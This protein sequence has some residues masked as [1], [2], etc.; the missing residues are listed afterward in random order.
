MHGLEWIDCRPEADQVVAAAEGRVVNLGRVAAHAHG[1]RLHA[2][3]GALR[4]RDLFALEMGR[5]FSRGQ[6]PGV[7]PRFVHEA[8]KTVATAL[9][10]AEVQRMDTWPQFSGKET[11]GH[12]PAVA[13][14][15]RLA[16][17]LA[18][19]RRHVRPL[20]DRQRFQIAERARGNEQG[21]ARAWSASSS[22]CIALAIILERSLQFQAAA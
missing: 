11:L 19:G 2:R 10:G 16:R 13:V 8:I 7:D 9:A 5:D 1:Q 4:R 21:A 20:A 6:R 18:V 3:S 14:E 15:P 22:V 17:F 12:D